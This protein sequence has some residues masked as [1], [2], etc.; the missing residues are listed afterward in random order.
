M[1]KILLA[2]PKAA[3]QG[4][5][6]NLVVDKL[7]AFEY[8]YM[9][10]GKWLFGEVGPFVDFLY[11]ENGYDKSFGGRD[12]EFKLV[13]GGSVKSDGVWWSGSANQIEKDTFVKVGVIDFAAFSKQQNCT[14][15]YS[16][17]IRKTELDAAIE[18]M[19][20]TTAEMTE[21][22]PSALDL[23]KPS[24]SGPQIKKGKPLSPN[25]LRKLNDPANQYTYLRDGYKWNPY[26]DYPANSDCPC[27]SQKKFK[28]CHRS[29]LN[30]TVKNEDYQPMRDFVDH[31]KRN[32][33][34]KFVPQEAPSDQINDQ[35]PQ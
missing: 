28:K 29:Q 32:P 6:Y 16:M 2:V 13:G 24:G 23:F 20:T 21:K 14:T 15:F 26:T 18:E 27:G 30:A 25:Q 19:K 31:V 1:S 22:F 33:T 12:L 11:H 4:G 5:G 7:P 35:P 9:N 17:E 3:D 34:L 8:Q 10:D